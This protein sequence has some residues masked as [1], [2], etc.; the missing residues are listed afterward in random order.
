M[1]CLL[2]GWYELSYLL[3]CSQA[4]YEYSYIETVALK[5][6]DSVLE[7][8]SWGEYWVEGVEGAKLPA[9]LADTFEV[10]HNKRSDK[11]H[12]FIVSLDN[13]FD[14]ERVVINVFKDMVSVKMGNSNT[15]SLGTS[16]GLLGTYEEGVPIGR[17]GTVLSLED[18]EAFA[19][20]WQVLEGEPKLFQN[21]ERY[22]Q[23]PAKC[24]RPD[25]ATKE[26]R[27]RLGTTIARE[28]AAAACAHWEHKEACIYDV[29]ATGDIELAS[30][31]PY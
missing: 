23:A 25:P 16:H 30:S 14:G 21:A 7:V 11:E 20:D 6:G 15:E 31:Q 9:K 10:T 3:F 8:A 17:N 19:E 18:P 2:F 4:R 22:P 27:R 24:V 1:F 12:Q 5:I 29:M 26:S 13:E 28:V